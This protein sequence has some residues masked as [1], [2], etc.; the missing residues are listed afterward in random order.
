MPIVA[1]CVVK[2]QRSHDAPERGPAA[3]E[4]KH[5]LGL[6]RVVHD[7]G[8]RPELTDQPDAQN[9]AKQV[10]EETETQA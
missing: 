6:S 10:K 9:Q 3:N 2:D 4:A 5:P 7:V 1:V 8:H